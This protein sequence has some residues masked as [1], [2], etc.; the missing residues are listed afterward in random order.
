MFK[1]VWNFGKKSNLLVKVQNSLEFYMN[2]PNFGRV[3]NSLE[4]NFHLLALCRNIF[5]YIKLLSI[6]PPL[7][8]QNNVVQL[9]SSLD[10]ITQ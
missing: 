3:Q 6:P 5:E 1:I 2:F 9:D 8:P 10:Y 7:S 4:N